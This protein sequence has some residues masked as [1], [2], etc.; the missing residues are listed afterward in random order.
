MTGVPDK[1][2]ESVRSGWGSIFGCLWRRNA[3]VGHLVG[4]SHFGKSGQ[5]ARAVAHVGK[6]RG[7]SGGG[8]ARARR[9]AEG[10]AERNPAFHVRV[11][12]PAST[13]GLSEKKPRGADLENYFVLRN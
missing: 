13:W 5:S 10:A 8:A 1:A 9:D 4:R 2:E 6:G 3:I 12:N 7:E 11:V